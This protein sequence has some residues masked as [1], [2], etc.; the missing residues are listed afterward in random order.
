MS[1]SSA[2]PDRAR[3]SI[4]RVVTVAAATLITALCVAPCAHGA[5]AP[6]VEYLYNVMVRR[7]YT[8]PTPTE[9]VNYGYGICEKVAQG[10]SYAQ[11]ARDVKSDMATND[12]FEASYLISYA[13]N[14]LCPA[15]IWQLRNSAASY[16]PEGTP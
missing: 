13:V 11:L 1:R 7:H 3:K 16:R 8:F 12:E 2:S 15:Q 4:L 10:D 5:P 9:A 6:E 14:L